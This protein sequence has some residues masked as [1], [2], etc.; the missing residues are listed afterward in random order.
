MY[1]NIK[2]S[3]YDNLHYV[4]GGIHVDRCRNTIVNEQIPICF[5]YLFF[6]QIQ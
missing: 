5:I 4:R 6:I 2:C 1:R 3:K